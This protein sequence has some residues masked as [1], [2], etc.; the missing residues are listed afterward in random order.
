MSGDERFKARVTKESLMLPDQFTRRGF[1]QTA[2]AMALS[3]AASA[4]PSL[5]AKIGFG[6]SLYGMKSLK[7]IQALRVCADIGYSSV[8]LA[9]LKDWPCAA[10]S[11][12]KAERA[13]L[14][15]E[16]E[17]LALDLPCL[18]E[19]LTL[20]APDEQHRANLERLKNVCQLGHDLSPDVTP[21]V[22]TVLG[23]K[24]DQWEA[25]REQMVV[26]LRE[27]EKVAA[28]QQTVVAIKAHVLGALHTPQ[29]AK[30][31]VQQIGS[32][33]IRL[34]YDYSHFQRQHLTLKESLE[35]MLPET[36]FVH[37]K[38]NLTTDG[39]TEFVLPGDAGDIDYT[40]YLKQ[41][42][43]AGYRGALVVEVSGQV[44]N[45]PGYD[46]IAAAKRCYKN[47]QPAFVKAGLR[48]EA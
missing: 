4:A 45:K 17:G 3:A 42:R 21:I 47:L 15:A 36:A 24:P 31:L 48:V 11:L 20:L 27:W 30:W 33:W 23:G 25:V 13:T 6:F 37:V 18:M 7:V 35:T 26:K 2:G 38:D 16:L 43:D 41:L 9:C 14:R 8:E 12:H 10:E 46:P 44:S 39:K 22:E 29:D 34:V 32:P 40:E 28:S 19:N 5:P 1:L